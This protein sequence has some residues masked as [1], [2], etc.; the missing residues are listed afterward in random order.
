MGNKEVANYLAETF[1]TRKEMGQFL[2]SPGVL[3]SFTGMHDAV[4]HA[5]DAVTHQSEILEGIL[6]TL[7]R[8]YQFEPDAKQLF[9]QA[10]DT[11]QK[12]RDVNHSR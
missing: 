3:H 5:I 7:E 11:F 12:V 6:D 1:P 4:G 10:I 8:Y 2:H 9:I